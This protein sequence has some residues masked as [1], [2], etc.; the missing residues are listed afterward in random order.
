MVFY[1]LT[2]ELLAV[3]LLVAALVIACVSHSKAKRVRLAVA[4]LAIV[5]PGLVLL[6][7]AATAPYFAQQRTLDLGWLPPLLQL[8]LI[9]YVAGVI[10]LGWRGFRVCPEGIRANHWPRARLATRLCIAIILLLLT[11]CLLYTSDAADE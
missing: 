9:G 7:P 3:F 6:A 8:G 11:L 2:A 10:A 4:A 5:L 1:L